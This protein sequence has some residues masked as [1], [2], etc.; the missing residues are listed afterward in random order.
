METD[1]IRTSGENTV[2]DIWIDGKMRSV[3]VSGEAIAALLR[4]TPERAAALGDEDRV[5]FVRTHLDLVVNM[6]RDRLR[7]MDSGAHAIAID[8]GAGRGQ[9]G[10]QAGERRNGDRR[11]GDRRKAN[12][13][14]PASGERRR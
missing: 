2:V 6:A 8:A 5:E 3:S 7:D 4:L 11:K 10:V 1:S 9:A 13:G 14:P 12:L